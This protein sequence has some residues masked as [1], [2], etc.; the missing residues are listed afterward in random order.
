M[1]I[2]PSCK[3][4]TR[5]VNDGG[6][7]PTF[8]EKDPGKGCPRKGR[9]REIRRLREADRNT[10]KNATTIFSCVG[11]GV[12]ARA[13]LDPV[14]GRGLDEGRAV[15]QSGA[16]AFHAL[17]EAAAGDEVLQRRDHAGDHRQLR[18]ALGAL[19]KVERFAAILNQRYSEA[20]KEIR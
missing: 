12:A 18:L 7:G 13:G 16:L 14:A 15:A 11:R 3:S 10:I 8:R 6:N 5:S 17:A 4:S 9:R 2:H 19:L 20:L 1:R